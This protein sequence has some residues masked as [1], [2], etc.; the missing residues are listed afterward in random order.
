MQKY[1]SPARFI[2]SD[3]PAIMAYA[4]QHTTGATTDEQ[5][6]IRLFEAVRDGFYYDPYN[7]ELTKEAFVASNILQRPRAYCIEKAIVLAAVLRA[8]NLPARLFFGNVRNHI[9]TE[10]FTEFLKTDIMVFHGSA[11]VFLHGKWIKLTPAFNK[12]L[13]EKLNVDPLVF[14]GTDDAIFQQYDRA[15]HKFMEYLQDYGSFDD[16]PYALLISEFKRH[17]GHIPYIKNW[18]EEG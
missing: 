6:A 14:N 15:N 1:L 8:A 3:H 16:L 10:K 9:A 4:R 17:Y 18:K 12:E 13:C 11:E 7:I 5:K 2:D